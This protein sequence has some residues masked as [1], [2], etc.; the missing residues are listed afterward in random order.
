MIQRK[1]RIP[2]RDLSTMAQ[3]DR[4]AIEKNA[5]GGRI[6]NIFKVL[7]HHPKL[8]KRWTPFAGH[9]L[10][11]Q[12]LPFRDRELLILRIGWLNQAEYEFAQHELIAKR[13]GVSDEDIARIKEG[14]KA[15][16]WSEKE[17]ALMQAA[18][19]L[20][21]NS[22]VSDATWATLSKSYS[23]EQLMDVVFTIGQYNLVSWAL[24]SFG[25]P[26]DDFLPGAKK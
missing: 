12:T 8:V 2:M 22:V 9:I 25:V 26:L 18:D 23:T 6:F 13:G 11:K 14:P 10:G 16:G 24:N 5:M 3:E 19:D 21:E 1:Q 4:E 17:A 20:Y 7:A 15:V